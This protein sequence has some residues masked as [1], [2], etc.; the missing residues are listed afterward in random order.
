MFTHC[1][2]PRDCFWMFQTLFIWIQRYN[3]NR[4]KM[5]SNHW[6]ECTRMKPL[7]RWSKWIYGSPNLESEWENYD[8]L[9]I[10]ILRKPVWPVAHT[11][12]TSLYCQKSQED[13][14]D[15]YVVQESWLCTRFEFSSVYDAFLASQGVDLPTLYIWRVKVDWGQP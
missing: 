6:F 1:T 5:R 7:S 8:D 14:S 15:R 10:L 4:S 13:Q 2:W 11:G 3:K 12:L 9:K